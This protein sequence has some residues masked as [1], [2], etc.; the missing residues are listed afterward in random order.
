MEVRAYRYAR[1]AWCYDELAAL[2]SLGAIPRAKAAAARAL[3]RDSRVLFA[4]VGRGSDALLAAQRGVDV[5]A[6]DTEPAMLRRFEQT[7]SDHGLRATAIEAD[8]FGYVPEQP[9]D[10][11]VASFA[12]NVF[13]GRELA[14][15]LDAAIGW[16]KPAGRLFVAD[17]APPGPGAVRRA[18]SQLHYWPVAVV[19]HS[20]GLCSLHPIHDYRRLLEERDLA[21]ES[22][23]DF[24]LYRLWRARLPGRTSV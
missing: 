6:L 19:A 21:V 16:L 23:D 7:L 12:L 15:A 17:F 13:D 14:G 24:G 4:G 5:F 10:A 20:L 11:V 8:W 18:F 22:E 9:F 3:A 1:V 2:W